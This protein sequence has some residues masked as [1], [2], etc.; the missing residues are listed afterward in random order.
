L[1]IEV[2]LFSLVEEENGW[3]S[4]DFVVTSNLWVN[5]GINLCELDWGL[6]Q[7]LPGEF[8]ASSSSAT[9]A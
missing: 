3:I 7:C 8:W 9:S 5:G 1:T 2:D 4:L 6:N